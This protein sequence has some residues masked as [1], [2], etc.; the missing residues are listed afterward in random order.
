[1][2]GKTV[3]DNKTIHRLNLPGLDVDDAVT[4]VTAAF[5]KFLSPHPGATLD[6][7]QHHARSGDAVRGLIF[8]SKLKH[9]A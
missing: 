2:V 9:Y 4:V 3:E 1:L 7:H 6:P 8:K 5:H